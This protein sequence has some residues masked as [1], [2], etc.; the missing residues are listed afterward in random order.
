[1]E[2][3]LVLPSRFDRKPA[4]FPQAKEPAT[5]CSIRSVDARLLASFYKQSRQLWVCQGAI[6]GI[7]IMYFAKA[8]A[9]IESRDSSGASGRHFNGAIGEHL[10]NRARGR[11]TSERWP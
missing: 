4:G 9:I 5:N 2:I 3:P 11:K 7:S 1:M 8:L 6:N 10:P